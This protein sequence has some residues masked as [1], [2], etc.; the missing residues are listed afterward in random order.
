MFSIAVI[1][2]IKIK[3]LSK[4][5]WGEKK[6][7]YFS[8]RHA[9]IQ[10]RNMEVELRQTLWGMLHTDL[11]STAYSVCFLIQPRVTGS[12]MLLPTVDWTHPHKSLIKK[13]THVDLPTHSPSYGD[14]CS[15]EVPLPR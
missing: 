5:T 10:S 14:V 15:I 2:M 12:A 1:N 4:G 8:Y 13:M 9:R 11:L 3:K 7:Y 6:A